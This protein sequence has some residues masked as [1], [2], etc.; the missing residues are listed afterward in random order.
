AVEAEAI[1]LRLAVEPRAARIAVAPEEAAAEPEA[2]ET[3]LQVDV[4]RAAGARRVGLRALR[5]GTFRL[6]LRRQ[7]Q[8]VVPARPAR[9][10]RRV[11]AARGGAARDAV[12]TQPPKNPPRFSR[13]PPPGPRRWAA[14]ATPATRTSL[15]RLRSP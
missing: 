12:W 2:V 14:G 7:Q 15:S 1:G 3:E 6:G 8:L 4:E 13:C 5:L 11:G 9:G 10:A